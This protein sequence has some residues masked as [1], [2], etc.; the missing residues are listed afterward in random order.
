MAR[1]HPVDGGGRRHD[2]LERVGGR[3]GRAARDAA[4]A[5]RLDGAGGTAGRIL[6]GW[7]LE[8][9][10]YGVRG[11]TPAPL[12]AGLAALAVEDAAAAAGRVLLGKAASLRPL[13]RSLAALTLLWA[14]LA[15][16]AVVAPGLARTQWNRFLRP[17]EDVP[18][19]SLTEFEL[20]PGDVTVVYGSELEIR[21]TVR[22]TPV[23]HLELILESAGGQEPALPMFPEPDG[24]WRAVLSRVVEP[25]EYFVPHRSGPQRQV[26][27]SRGDR[28]ADRRVRG[29]ASCSRST[30]TARLR[31]AVAER[32][33]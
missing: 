14:G 24:V 13:S 4:V 28:A 19:F 3:D 26:S 21:A 10:R 20:A 16:V 31:R 18:P 32:R 23:E 6:T 22:G 9:G 11:E 30:P 1:C 27:H 15:V 7:E 17:F 8:Q 25:A 2:P 5:R 33:H 12:S 29:S